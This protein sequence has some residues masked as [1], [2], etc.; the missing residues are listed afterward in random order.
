MINLG[1]SILLTITTILFLLIFHIETNTT[2]FATGIFQLLVYFS[3]LSLT[4][5]FIVVFGPAGMLFNILSLSLQLVTS[6]VIVP[7]SMLSG[8]YQTIGSLLPA[9]YVADGYYTVIFGGEKLTADMKILLSISAV[10]LLA[11]SIRIVL[12][13][14]SLFTVK[15]VEDVV[16]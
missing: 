1:A 5:M 13:K 11:A 4:Q 3:F 9:T 16:Q 8:F 12:Q 14:N 2:L 7:K 15:E 10:S 6:G